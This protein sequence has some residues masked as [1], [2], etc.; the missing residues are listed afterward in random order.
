[1]NTFM[2]R[3]NAIVQQNQQPQNMMAAPQPEPSYPDAG[4]GALSSVANGAPR[5]TEIM[6]Q[7]HMLAYINPQEEAMIQSQRGGM[8]AFEGPG[9]VPAYWF[10]SSSGPSFSESVS[11][12]KDKVT[13]WF[14]GTPTTTATP[15]VTNNN[16]SAYVA[17]VVTTPVVTKARENNAP[18]PTVFYNDYTDPDNPVLD[19]MSAVADRRVGDGSTSSAY[20]LAND[21][22]FTDTS[23]VTTDFGSDSENATAI[24]TALSEANA[25]FEISLTLSAPGKS[26]D[27][28][29]Y[30]VDANGTWQGNL[31]KNTITETLANWFTPLDNAKYENGQLINSS[32]GESLAGGGTT[33]NVFGFDDTIY[34]VADDFSNNIVDTTGLS[35]KDANYKIKTA[36]D[37]ETVPPSMTEYL[38]SFVPLLLPGD[39]GVVGNYLG[40]QYLQD[41]IDE[42]RQ[43]IDNNL[44]NLDYDP[45]GG[46]TTI[47]ALPATT[48]TSVTGANAYEEYA[49]SMKAAGL[50]SLGGKQIPDDPFNQGNTPIF[51]NFTDNLGNSRVEVFGALNDNNDAINA[52]LVAQG[53]D[54]IYGSDDETPT[55]SYNEDGTLFIPYNGSDPATINANTQFYGST[56]PKAADYNM[57]KDLAETGSYVNLNGETVTGEAFETNLPENGAATLNE[58]GK[59]HLLETGDDSKM[60]VGAPGG[61]YMFID[62]TPITNTVFTEAVFEAVEDGLLNEEIIE[63]IEVPVDTECPTGYSY[64]EST[65]SCVKDTVI[66]DDPPEEEET[67]DDNDSVSTTTVVTTTVDEL[68]DQL[69]NRYYKGGSGKFLPAWLQKYVSGTSLDQLLSKVTVDGK[70]YYKTPDGKYIEASELI[71]A[72]NLGPE[73]TLEEKTGNQTE[74]VTTTQTTEEEPEG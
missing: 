53:K 32:T 41:G 22:N 34:G 55:M 74:T 1:M 56:D 4:M 25:E 3:V 63:I 38:T 20:A 33:K 5:Q 51:K 54:P 12:A 31:P 47:G 59:N 13:S 17:P 72:A 19:T 44:N 39:L 10:H 9:G 26:Y 18:A 71:G 35:N 11:K 64:N 40:S 69:Y 15:V 29:E 58:L 57:S 30:Y 8:P 48:E 52:T 27:G 28:Q 73:L 14:S 21:T 68:A 23:G 2:D 49:N 6:G 16:T 66:N 37:L 65:S 45:L 60:I 50:L 42:R 62:G 46:N 70:D 24:N 7:P 61:G 36:E 43:A 67:K